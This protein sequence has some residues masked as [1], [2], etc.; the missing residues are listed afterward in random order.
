MK[1]VLKRS[2]S[3]A[4]SAMSG[5]GYCRAA[6]TKCLVCAEQSRK[7]ADLAA[8]VVRATRHAAPLRPTR[9]A[10][11][12][13]RGTAALHA[14]HGAAA[15]ASRRPPI[16][17]PSSGRRFRPASSLCTVCAPRGSHATCALDGAGF[18][19]GGAGLGGRARDGGVRCAEEEALDSAQ[20]HP[21]QLEDARARHSHRALRLV[22]KAQAEAYCVWQLW[23]HD[24]D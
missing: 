14:A 24:D 15:P 1:S 7:S 22:R 17:R 23:R 11:S 3:R 19:L 18:D 16:G 10:R 5:G 13:P 4:S 2:N 9:A 20:P 21:P 8:A 6:L 12:R